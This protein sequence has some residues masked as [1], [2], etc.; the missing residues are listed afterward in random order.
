EP[1]RRRRRA[2]HADVADLALPRGR[3]PC[4]GAEPVSARVAAEF[5]NRFAPV[6]LAPTAF[7]PCY[8]LAEATLAVTVTPVDERFRSLRVARPSLARLGEVA[9]VAPHGRPEDAEV[10]VV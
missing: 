4:C 3:S 10:D 6:G 5:T 8:G 2:G 7:T 9:V 1:P